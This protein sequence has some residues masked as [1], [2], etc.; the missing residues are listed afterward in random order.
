MEYKVLIASDGA[1]L[2][3]AVNEAIRAGWM[4]QGGV[5]VTQDSRVWENER[6]GYTEHETETTYAQAMVLPVS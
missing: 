2:S 1:S 3:D 6:K 4:P 5:A